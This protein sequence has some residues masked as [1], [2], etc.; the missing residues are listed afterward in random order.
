MKKLII[1]L[2]SI[3]LLLGFVVFSTYFVD[4]MRI[5][6]GKEPL[7]AICTTEMNDGGSKVYYGLGYQIIMWK[8][9]TDEPDI[10]NVGY[11][12]HLLFQFVDPLNGPNVEL[13]NVY[14]AE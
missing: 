8:R 1:I 10:L 13:A 11:E 7:F 6:A 14:Q 4:L 2:I 5:S 3:F 12:I 9:L